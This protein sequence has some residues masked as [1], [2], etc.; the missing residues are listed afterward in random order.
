[1]VASSPACCTARWAWWMESWIGSMQSW[2][3]KPDRLPQA[4]RLRSWPE[5]QS[6]TCRLSLRSRVK[7]CES[8]TSAT[9]RARSV[10][11][12]AGV[13]QQ[14]SLS[15]ECPNQLL[16]IQVE[17]HFNYF[18]ETEECFRRCRSAHTASNPRMLLTPIDWALVESWK[19]AGIPLAA[20]LAGIERTFEKWQKRP[21]R[22]QRI[23][24]VGFCSQE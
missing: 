16:D 21:R 5:H 22:F 3:Q 13:L 1:W 24:S 15:T 23:N 10:D 20:V 12:Q 8:S 17:N 9:C 18:T 4:V 6:T 19:D 14:T 2:V 7:V 11:K